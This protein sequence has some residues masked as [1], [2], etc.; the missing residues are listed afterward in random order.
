MQLEVDSLFTTDSTTQEDAS[1]QAQVV[2]EYGRDIIRNMKSSQTKMTGNFE[3]HEIKG[4]HRKQM[5]IWIEEVFK[6]LKCPVEMFFLSVSIMD[7][8]F[9][10]AKERL[11]LDDLHEIGIASM[12]IASKYQEIEPL[13]LDLVIDRIAHKKISERKLLKREKKILTA[14]KFKL[15][16]PTVWAFIENYCEIFE[17]KFG[18][19]EAKTSIK[20]LA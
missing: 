8:Y 10:N 12:F 20:V 16:K 11:A 13:T 1:V 17:S 15:S 4:S 2:S 19:D 5:V 3:R 18:S 9:E 7:R 6:I 14:L